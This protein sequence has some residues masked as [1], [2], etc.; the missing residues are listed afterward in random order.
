MANLEGSHKSRSCTKQPGSVQTK[1]VTLRLHCRSQVL[2][3]WTV[4]PGDNVSHDIHWLNLWRSETLVQ[5]GHV[6][7]VCVQ[8]HQLIAQ[9]TPV[10]S[11]YWKTSH[12]CGPLIL[13]RSLYS[14]CYTEHPFHSPLVSDPFMTYVLWV[15]D[16]RSILRSAPSAQALTPMH[17]EERKK[18]GQMLW[19]RQRHI[20]PIRSRNVTPNN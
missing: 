5:G 19:L 12:L 4:C 9:L 16:K 11:F 14:S 1:N 7:S 20:N 15:N 8:S 3:D 13:P 17:R 6:R 2:N 10:H 18:L